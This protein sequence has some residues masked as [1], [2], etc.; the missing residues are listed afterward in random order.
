MKFSAVFIIKNEDSLVQKLLAPG[1]LQ[2]CHSEICNSTLFRVNVDLN[3]RRLWCYSL[4]SY[5]LVVN[6]IHFGIYNDASNWY[7]P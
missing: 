5:L 7:V 4:Y 1:K 3:F 2:R 6:T